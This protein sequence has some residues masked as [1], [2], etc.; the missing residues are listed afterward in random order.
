MFPHLCI[1]TNLCW[2]C[3]HEIQP[4]IAV[5][6]GEHEARGDSGRG[7]S[8]GHGVGVTCLVSSL[9][10]DRLGRW[11]EGEGEEMDLDLDLWS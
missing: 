7:G 5:E 11:E 9:V 8:P 3:P 6:V 4:R 1:F 10:V 2:H